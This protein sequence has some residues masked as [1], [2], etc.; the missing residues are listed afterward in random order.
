M[1][2]SIEVAPYAF[3]RKV[4]KNI[5]MAKMNKVVTVRQTNFLKINQQ[6][7][8][9]SYFLNQIHTKII[10]EIRYRVIDNKA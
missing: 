9:L 5:N 4:A 3:T 8:S 6:E 1:I 2:F 10:N 7:S